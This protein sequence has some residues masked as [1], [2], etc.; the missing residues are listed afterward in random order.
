MSRAPARHVLHHNGQLARSRHERRREVLGDERTRALR[1]NGNLALNVGDV[2]LGVLE[3]D[4]LDGDDVSIREV[5]RFEHLARGAASDA[6]EEG[7]AIVDDGTVFSHV[8]ARRA[9]EVRGARR[10]VRGR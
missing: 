10:R 7:V 1:E 5:E 6:R 2:V 9:R 4:E 8:D 3:I